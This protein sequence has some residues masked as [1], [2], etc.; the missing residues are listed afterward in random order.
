VRGRTSPGHAGADQLDVTRR[1]RSSAWGWHRRN[2]RVGGV[3]TRG[4]LDRFGLLRAPG[5]VS[6][7]PDESAV[8]DN[9]TRGRKARPSPGTVGM[10]TPGTECPTGRSLRGGEGE[11]VPERPLQLRSM[12]PVLTCLR[13]LWLVLLVLRVLN[14]GHNVPPLLICRWVIFSR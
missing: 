5:E 13:G 7:V 6:D 14:D 2:A 9:V 1:A 11:S 3:H 10:R 4:S 8:P 12:I